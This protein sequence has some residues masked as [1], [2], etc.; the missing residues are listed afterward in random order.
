MRPLRAATLILYLE[1]AEKSPLAETLSSFWSSARPLTPLNEAFIYPPHATVTG[2]WTTTVDLAS[3]DPFH[4][5]VVGAALVQVFGPIPA[6]APPPPDVGP[7]VVVD[8][9]GGIILPVAP[10]AALPALALLLANR[11]AGV[12]PKA[13]NHIS[14][15][16]GAYVG[17]G[18]IAALERL[19]R[20]LVDPCVA[21]ERSA[22]GWD[23]VWY[24]LEQRGEAGLGLAHQFRE[25]RRWCVWPSSRVEMDHE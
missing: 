13:V 3:P 9:G 15:A 23:L 24:E 4:A 22:W 21:E 7:A 10:P 1:P 5:A 25:I 2:F 19:A 11:L 14:L 16:Y 18:D 12:R 20:E 17:P 8:N 6:T